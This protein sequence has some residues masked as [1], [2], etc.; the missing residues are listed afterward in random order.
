[1]EKFGIGIRKR[2]KGGQRANYG[3]LCFILFHRAVIKIEFEELGF[4]IMGCGDDGGK[5][6]GW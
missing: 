6:R 4:K 3:F 2:K 5:Y 1:M